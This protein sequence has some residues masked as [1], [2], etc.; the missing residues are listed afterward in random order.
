[1][2]LCLEASDRTETYLEVSAL[3]FLYLR[4]TKWFEKVFEA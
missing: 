2:F 4:K 1:L 3:L